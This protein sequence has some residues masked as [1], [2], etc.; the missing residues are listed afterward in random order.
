MPGPF[1]DLSWVLERNACSDHWK[2]FI[3]EY[4]NGAETNATTLRRS[5]ELGLSMEWL[6][7]R[8]LTDAGLA[9]FTEQKPWWP[10]E[11]PRGEVWIAHNITLAALINTIGE[12][13]NWRMS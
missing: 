12:A 1:V 3:R 5:A 7:K 11:M 8:V 6:A 13:G 10:E 2:P 4:P 9:L